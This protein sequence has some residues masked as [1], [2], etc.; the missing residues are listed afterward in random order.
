MKRSQFKSGD[1]DVS[2][3]AVLHHA[4]SL[5]ARLANVETKQPPP[6]EHAVL[7]VNSLVFFVSFFF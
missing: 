3:S 4:H 2:S 5:A 6:Y 1:S 7:Q